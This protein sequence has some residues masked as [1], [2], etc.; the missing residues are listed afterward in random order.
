MNNRSG[1][2]GDHVTLQAAADSVCFSFLPIF[3]VSF[4]FFSAIILLSSF[5][6]SFSFFDVAGCYYIFPLNLMS[7]CSVDI[8]T[9]CDNFDVGFMEFGAS[10]MVQLYFKLCQESTG[11]E[12][13][14][15]NMVII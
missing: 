12:N 9:F 5:S 8:L 2:W 3:T 1:E 6:F 14:V 4:L 7:Y 10:P 11:D 13:V 15:H